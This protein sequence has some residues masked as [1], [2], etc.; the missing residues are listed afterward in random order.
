[1]DE[2]N[3]ETTEQPK[4]PQE[5]PR[6]HSLWRLGLALVLVGLVGWFFLRGTHGPS[7]PPSPDEKAA[8]APE[9]QVQPGP[10]GSA[11]PRAVAGVPAA[12]ATAALRSQLEKVLTGIRAANQEKDLSQL[13]SHYSPNFPQLTQRAQSISKTWKIYDYPKMDF[14]ITELKSITGDTVDARVTWDVEAK[15][16]STQKSQ[17]IS[18]AYWIRFVKESGQWRIKALDQAG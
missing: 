1:M 10:N 18:K 4:S 15:N 17:N 7:A 3:R 11:S 16:I 2:L 9:T 6:R 5:P 12:E 8:K 13:L 14:T